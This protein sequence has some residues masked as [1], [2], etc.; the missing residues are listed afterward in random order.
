M[1]NRLIRQLVFGLGSLVFVSSMLYAQDTDA[2]PTTYN[3]VLTSVPT[4]NISPNARAA[5]MADMGVSTLP[6]VASQY[7]NPSKYAF[8]SNK[9]GFTMSYTP[10][11]AK[12]VK[13]IKL[14]EVGGYYKLGEENNQ[15]LSASLRYFSFGRVEQFDNMARSLGEASPNEFAVDL[16]YSLQLSSTYSMGVVLRYLRTDNNLATGEQSAGNAFAADISGF[17]NNYFDI[18]EAESLWTMG[19]NIKNIG[20]KL[21]YSNGSLSRYIPTNMVLGTGILYPFDEYNALSFN[22]E[23]NKLL[24][25]TPPRK[26]PSN[27]EAYE[28][29]ANDYYN[30]S[31]IAGIF[32]SF[33]DAPGGFSE[34][35]KEIS[36]GVGAEYSYNNSFFLRAGYHY[37]H[38]DKGNLQ[39]FTAGA[40]FKMSVFSIDASYLFSTVQSNPLDQTLRISISFDMDGLRHLLQ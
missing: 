31:S 3:P 38:P 30:K 13:D 21:T 14:M 37:I 19:F 6:D 16:G 1:K 39:Y 7:Y 8:L 4:M 23:A 5:G 26:N 9:A 32:S 10:W 27:P 24:V 20:T 17:Y 29:A 36:Y 12:L 18:G 35:L 2:T 15:A 22:V 25:P 33:A 28:K 34:E 11:L 40:G